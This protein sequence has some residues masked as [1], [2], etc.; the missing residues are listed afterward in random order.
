MRNHE[1]RDWPARGSRD[2]EPKQKSGR[3]ILE[4]A[5]RLMVANS[6]ALYTIIQR[7]PDMIRDVAAAVVSARTETRQHNED[8]ELRGNGPCYCDQ[9]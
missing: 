8:C 7:D 5:K 4:A 9:K 2:V 1:H 6:Y 3:D